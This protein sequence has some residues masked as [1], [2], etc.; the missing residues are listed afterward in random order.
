MLVLVGMEY[1]L[2]VKFC[3]EYKNEW[4]IILFLKG[5][6]LCGVRDGLQQI[7]N[8]VGNI[9]FDKGCEIVF[10]IRGKI[11]FYKQ[12]ERKYC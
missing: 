6:Y 10:L 12:K 3:W 2:Y 8:F 4:D 5:L 1:S 7:V 9:S 11:D